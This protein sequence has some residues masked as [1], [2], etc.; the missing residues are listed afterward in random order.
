MTCFID[1]MQPITP[2]E[3]AAWK[4]F[5]TLPLPAWKP[6]RALFQRGSEGQE[7]RLN[8]VHF[9]AESGITDQDTLE[10]LDKALRDLA[11]E[12]EGAH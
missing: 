4:L 12:K 8:A 7:P 10:A 5:L 2:A 9:A 3:K 1:T 6:A 11:E